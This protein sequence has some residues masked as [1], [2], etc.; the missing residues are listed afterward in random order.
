MKAVAG[1]IFVASTFLVASV[2]RAQAD[3]RI[4]SSAESV[5]PLGVG[6]TVPGVEL[7][8]VAGL[9]VALRAL[10]ARQPT[11]LVFY[12][13][14]WCPYC[15]TQL[16][17]LKKIEG[18]LGDLGYQLV[19]ISPD[20]PE[21]LAESVAKQ[22]LGYALL[23]DSTADAIKAFGLAFRVDDDTLARYRN[24]GIDLEQT[25]GAGHHLLPVP[26]VYVVD[27]SGRI[28]FAYWNADYKQRL[29]ADKVVAAARAAASRGD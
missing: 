8:S 19:A 15:N 25:S 23:S 16:S 5:R 29:D 27:P 26:A 10:V 20:K 12:R 18:T 6:D 9:P 1:M 24:F 21:K 2:V 11:V 7:R 13:G 17:G 3:E 22:K 28:L 4:A 14:G